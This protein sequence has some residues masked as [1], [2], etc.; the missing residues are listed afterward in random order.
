MIEYKTR[1]KIPINLVG[2]KTY[3]LEKPFNN[4]ERMV[5]EEMNTFKKS[6]IIVISYLL[7]I[8][9]AGLVILTS[10]EA[11]AQSNYSLYD[12]AVNYDYITVTIQGDYSGSTSYFNLE[13][14]DGIFF[15]KCIELEVTNTVSTTLHITVNLG[16]RLICRESGIQNM[17]VTKEHT[18]T[19]SSYE[20]ETFTV[21]A[22]CMNMYE[23][24]PVAGIYY[25]LGSVCSGDAYN[26]VNKI[27]SSTSQNAAGQCALWAVTDSADGDYLREYGA[28]DN[29]LNSAQGILDDADISYNIEEGSRGIPL[30]WIIVIV[31]IVIVVILIVII[32]MLKQKKRRLPAP[33]VQPIPP[34][35]SGPPVQPAPPVQPEP[36]VQTTP[37]FCTNC[38]A[39]SKPGVKFCTECGHQL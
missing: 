13:T 33:P 30:I 3:I 14:G 8:S 9:V 32:V 38:G 23:D 36:P 28:S 11:E 16:R 4:L 10:N 15:G 35:Q 34:V 20:T 24:A 7:I 19:L 18:F 27:S 1:V 12:A 22:M 6:N 25:D 26:A 5:W 17:V 29:D 2:K 37:K 21:Y 39:T 31:I